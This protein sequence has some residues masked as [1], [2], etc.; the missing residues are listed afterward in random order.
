MVSIEEAQGVI[1]QHTARLPMEEV[2]LVEGLGRVLARD[3][4][5]PFDVPL[6]DNSAMD[7]YAFSF[8]FVHG[9]RL[10][11][12]GFL[13]AGHP[14]F[15][16]VPPGC[17]VKIMTGAPIPPGCDT[18]VPIEETE[19]LAG[20]IR[21]TAGPRQGSHI[22]RRGEDVKASEQ[23][24]AQ[25]KI[26]RPQEI[27]MLASLGMT[28]MP[29]FAKPTAAILATGDELLPLGQTPH[30]G[31]IVNSNSIAIAAQ[32]KEAGATP[33][34]FGIAPDDFEATKRA[35]REALATADLLITTGG[36][37]VG[38]KDYVKVAIEELGGRILFWKV[39]M[40]PGKP[41]AFAVLDRKPIFALPGNPVAAMVGFELFVRPALLKMRGCS[42]VMRPVIK[43]RL[44]EPLANK[45][46][47]PT[48]VRALVSFQ[49]DE[50]RVAVAGNQGS[51]NIL[52]MVRSNGLL[53]L[54]PA[55]ALAAGDVAEVILLDGGR[56]GQG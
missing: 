37:S 15:D 44:Q 31:Q 1:L 40:K 53:K 27:A 24:V 5:S 29:V 34:D 25:G 4:L 10:P 52:S 22:R 20:E 56:E 3:I 55:V 32:L 42:R 17:A 6:T 43:A 41:V 47:R 14:Q 7:G 33:V 19:S 11:V 39:N 26:V 30:P 9:D 54:P 28:T 51:A 35:I 16:A 13:A 49:E 38:D 36:V 48:L 46:E 2:P 23:V 18:V 45:G 50:P 8:H 21:L 12:S